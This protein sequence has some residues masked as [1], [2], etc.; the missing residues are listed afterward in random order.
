ML[1]FKETKCKT[2]FN[3]GKSL[4]MI[5][6]TASCTWPD[7]RAPE[8]LCKVSI[9]SSKKRLH[10]KKKR[11]QK[12]LVWITTVT[13]ILWERCSSHIR[14]FFRHS[15]D[16]LGFIGPQMSDIGVYRRILCMKPFL[17]RSYWYLTSGFRNSLI[18]PCTAGRVGD[19]CQRFSFIKACLTLCF[20]KR[21]H[22]LHFP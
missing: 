15:L 2:C 21:K 18:G 13:H 1:C 12:F 3:V 10:T 6:Y 22:D 20:F 19:Q 11:T 9:R 14:H 7:E 4:T 5:S 17:W 8:S 16:S